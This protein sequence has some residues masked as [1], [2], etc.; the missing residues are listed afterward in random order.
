[1]KGYC[2]VSE[3]N[4]THIVFRLQPPKQ[5]VAPEPILYMCSLC[6]EKVHSHHTQQH[7]TDHDGVESYELD[8]V[9]EHLSINPTEHTVDFD[10]AG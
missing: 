6:D 2:S 5:L 3:P 10:N 7:A 8:N 9:G 1:M 4:N